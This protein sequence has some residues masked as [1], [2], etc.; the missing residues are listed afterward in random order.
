MLFHGTVGTLVADRASYEVIPE[1]KIHRGMLHSHA[2]T[3]L[4]AS[5][6]GE[7]QARPK[8]QPAPQCEPLK[9]TGM[10]IDPSSQEAHVRN[11]FECMRS[12]H[13]PVPD[14]EIGHRSVTA[15][16]L[17]VIAYKVGRKIRW[18]AQQEKIVGDAEAQ[19]LLSKQ[20]RAPW[21]LPGV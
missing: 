2:V 10:S 16:H 9:E 20:Y 19:R 18:D 14:V 21:S 1:M 11:F 17:G 5:P 15:C 6:H 13:Q 7:R 3:E 12:R 4:L 8:P